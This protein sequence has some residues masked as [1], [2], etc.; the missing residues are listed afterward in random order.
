MPDGLKQVAQRRKSIS[1]PK[2]KEGLF[3]SDHRPEDFSVS[4]LK[5]D[6]VMDQYS[7]VFLSSWWEDPY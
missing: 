3:S 6:Q 4:D 1:E 7:T 5:G 2:T